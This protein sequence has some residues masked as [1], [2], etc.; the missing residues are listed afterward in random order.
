MKYNPKDRTRLSG[1]KAYNSKTYINSREARSIRI[2]CEIA[3]PGIRLKR[4]G[5]NHTIQFFGSARTGEGH[6]YY[7]KAYELSSEVGKWIKA[8][9]ERS[10][11]AIGSGGGP[12]IMEAVNRGAFDAG[13][14]S[15]G[16]GISLPFEQSNNEYVSPELDFEFHYFFTRKYWCV[17]L[18]KAYVALPGGVGTLDELFEILT[19]IQTKKMPPVPIVLYDR[20]FWTSVVDFNKLVSVGTVAKEDLDLFRICDTVDEAMTYITS[21]LTTDILV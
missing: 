6:P 18:S 8:E 13:V 1:T 12:G 4:L 20:E 9:D 3:E 14:K 7:D 10:D 15:V 5:V 19:L 11:I 21:G 2:Q 16:M 17:Y